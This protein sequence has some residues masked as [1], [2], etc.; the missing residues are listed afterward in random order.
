MWKS[1]LEETDF[2]R[3][4]LACQLT[5]LKFEQYR[6]NQTYQQKAIQTRFYPHDY[7]AAIDDKVFFY[8]DL[9]KGLLSYTAVT[10]LVNGV[11]V[12]HFV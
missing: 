6:T 8:S 1:L 10:S 2:S 5:Q 7:Q 4:V 11:T 12:V 9:G 3:K